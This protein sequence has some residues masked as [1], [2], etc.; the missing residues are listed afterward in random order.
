MGQAK[1]RTFPIGVCIYCGN[2][3]SL[4]DEHV[5]PYGLGGDLVLNE[6]SCSACCEITKKLEGR[7]LRGH[8]WPYRRFLG[9]KSRRPKEQ[10]PDLPV[11]VR[12]SDGV[13]SKAL[14]PI[15]QQTIA[16]VFELD[17]PSI[18]RNEI[19]TDIPSA[20]RVYMKH[21]AQLP[22]TVYIDNKE[23]KLSGDDKLDVPVSFDASDLCRFLAKVAHC[24]AISR[25]GTNACYEYY[26]PEIVLGKVE[27]AL[28][29]VGGAD[30]PFI[31][32]HL[33]GSAIHSLMDRVNDGY[34]SV[35]IQ[36]FRDKGD[37]P[38]IYEVIVGRI[39]K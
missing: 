28:T 25:R 19:C 6:A 31:E 18:L 24:Y 39:I 20:P 23:Y 36:L 22:S 3:D 30:S 9:L 10:N 7:L 8:W 27:G 37:P 14:L 2:T 29:Y 38:P 4:T 5:I 11:T 1:K 35:Y 26:L 15:S 33:P 17:P 21:F 32:K 13:E 12:H 34:L 16:L